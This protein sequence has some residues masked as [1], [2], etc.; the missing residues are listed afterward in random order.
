MQ[1]QQRKKRPAAGEERPAA[2]RPSLSAIGLESEFVLF[3][4]DVPV[5]PAETFGD[6]R[7]FLR[8]APMHREG[9]SYHLPT[10]GAVYFDT[11]VV[12]VATPLIEIGPG[13]AARAVRS[14][15]ESIRHVRGELD[16]WEARSARRAR[17]A[18]FSAHYNV[19][20]NAPPAARRTGDPERSIGALALLLS[21]LLPVP[22]MVLAANRRSTGIGVRPRGDRIEVTVDFTP[23][24]ALMMAAATLIAGVVRE[25]MRWP[26]YALERLEAERLPR[27]CGFSP[28]PHSSRRGWVARFSC[29]PENPFL[30]NPDAPTWR[31]IDGPTRSLRGM[32]RTVLHHF[33]APIRRLADPATYRLMAAIFA[34]RATSPL[35]GADRQPEYDDVGRLCAWDFLAPQQGLERSRYERVLMHAVAGRVLRVGGEVY[36]PIGVRGWH[37]VRFRRQRDGS[38]HCFDL[39][40]LDNRLRDWEA[41]PASRETR[42]PRRRKDDGR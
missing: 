15:W 7:G 32:A 22:V 30:A 26:D 27:L 36:T 2:G 13:C 29:F 20:F 33:R 42:A 6:P 4:D 10:G 8:G 23:S 12:E 17:L 38:D 39:P 9:T 16:A 1:Q 19:S 25:V 3:V 14:L 5:D 18:G 21:H 31:T 34:G 28:V 40:F 35:D 11:G 37:A 24:P 41:E